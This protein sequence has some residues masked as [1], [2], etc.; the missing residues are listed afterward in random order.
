MKM[1]SRLFLLT[2]IAGAIIL[3]VGCGGSSEAPAEAPAALITSEKFPGITCETTKVAMRDGVKLTTYVY[4]PAG[5]TGKLPVLLSRNPYGRGL[6]DGCFSGLVLSKLPMVQHGYAVVLQVVRGAFT[7][8]GNFGLMTQEADDGYDA[9]EWAG[10]RSWSTGKVGMLGGSYLGLTQWQAAIKSPPHLVA[11]APDL[12]GSDYH[13]NWTYVNGVFS[14]WLNVSWPAGL[15]EADQIIRSGEAAGKTKLQIDTEAAA[16][17]ASLDSSLTWAATLPLTSISQFKAHQPYFYDWL[18]HPYYDDY[19]KKM[20][21]EAN[22]PNVKVPALVGGYSYDL[23][24]VGAARNYQGMRASAGTTQARSGTKLVWG[25]YGHSGDSGAPSFGSDAGPDPEI[26]LRFFD[27]YVKGLQNGF[28][29]EPNARIYVMVPPDSGKAGSGF[30]VSGDDFPLPGTNYVK[31]F[32]TSN[33]NAATRSGDGRLTANAAGLGSADRDKFSYDPANPVPTV[34][35]NMCCDG[36]RVPAG[37]REQ[38]SVEAR[39]DVLVYTSEPLATDLPVIGMVKSTFWAETSAKDTDFTVK[40]VVVRPDGQT[41]NVVDRIVRASLRAGS[42]LP[43]TPIQPNTPYQYTLEVGNTAMVV[44]KGHRLRVQVSSSN[45][46]IYARNLNTGKDSNST[47]E[48]IV[49][50]Q[51]LLH[52]AT[53]LSY[54]ELPIAPISRPR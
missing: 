22:Y 29:S 17:A 26:E 19:W 35:G 50:N 1:K 39:P 25:A 24:N 7:S 38:A 16:W 42:K 18:A 13:D 40:L 31:Y 34:G 20:D 45:F 37:A 28:E 11:I 54:I 12:T 6:A 21:V 48:M 44:P 49:A 8:E 27:R 32:M 23:F 51:T 4:K 33:G 41:H 15:F 36:V 53:Q 2:A 46:P 3:P 14:P 10:T 5:E 43:P 52:G 47:S 30:W 9:V